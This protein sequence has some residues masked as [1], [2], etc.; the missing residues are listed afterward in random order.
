MKLLSVHVWS[1]RTAIRALTELCLT[2]FVLSREVAVVYSD[3]K[4]LS[5]EKHMGRVFSSTGATSSTASKFARRGQVLLT[6]TSRIR[7]GRK[8]QAEKP[9]IGSCEKRGESETTRIQLVQE[10]R[11]EPVVGLIQLLTELV[12]RQESPSSAVVL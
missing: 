2:E 10:A 1:E 7:D 3:N 9:I 4:L 12:E 11:E 6:T 5:P 8:S